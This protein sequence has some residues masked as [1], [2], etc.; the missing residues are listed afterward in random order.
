[1]TCAACGGEL[2]PFPPRMI[3]RDLYCDRCTY[4]GDALAHAHA[5]WLD[6]LRAAGVAWSFENLAGGCMVLAIPLS[7]DGARYAWLGW[8]DTLDDLLVSDLPPMRG[9]FI[10][11]CVYVNDEHGDQLTSGEL[12][13]VRVADTTPEAIVDAV[14]TMAMAAMSYPDARMVPI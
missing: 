7:E 6:P 11:G 3:G 1:M 2:G 5:W 9:W 14:K 12:D 8:S 10:T 13:P 4:Y